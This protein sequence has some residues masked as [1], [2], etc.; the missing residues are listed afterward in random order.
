MQD[1][2]TSHHLS[3]QTKSKKKSANLNASSIGGLSQALLDEEYML[4]N[5]EDDGDGG[6]ATSNGKARIKTRREGGKS[7]SPF[8]LNV[9]DSI[10]ENMQNTTAAGCDPYA[11]G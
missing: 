11:N 7:N 3:P 5:S 4:S 10:Q 9:N 8:K 1:G 6:C 2:S